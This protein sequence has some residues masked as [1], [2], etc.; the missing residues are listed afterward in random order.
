MLCVL[1]SVCVSC[2]FPWLCSSL[3]V[4]FVLLW[5]FAFILSYFTITT[6]ILDACLYSN[7]REKECGFGCEGSGACLGG[8]GG[9]ERVIRIYN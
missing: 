1:V 6:T 5:F 2:V 7:V 4:N 3:F 9:G 8:I